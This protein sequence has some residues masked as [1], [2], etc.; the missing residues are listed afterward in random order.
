MKNKKERY[1]GIQQ[2]AKEFAITI[3][4]AR[5]ALMVGRIMDLNG[6]P[7]KEEYAEPRTTHDNQVWFAWSESKAH[8]AFIKAGLKKPTKIDLY[9]H[10]QN[11]QQALTRL[12]D[13]FS[14]I[15]EISKLELA[16]QN[17]AGLKPAHDI[18]CGSNIALLH[19]ATPAD[20]DAFLTKI[21]HAIDEYETTCISICANKKQVAE[22]VFYASAIRKVAGWVQMQ[23]FR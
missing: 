21:H 17:D 8:K 13:A 23:F 9:S 3:P 10:V 4:K 12:D 2:L 6:Q 16:Y 18:Y 14:K 1:I 15:A 5:K 7:V 22:V 20:C 19:M 11:R